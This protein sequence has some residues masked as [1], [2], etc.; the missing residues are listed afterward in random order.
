[1]S[2][3]AAIAQ[4]QAHQKI[5]KMKTNAGFL[6]FKL[7]QPTS[8]ETETVEHKSMLL[9]IDA[10]SDLEMLLA[11]IASMPYK[12]ATNFSICLCLLQHKNLS[13]QC[14]QVHVPGLWHKLSAEIHVNAYFISSLLEPPYRKKI[15]CLVTCQQIF[16]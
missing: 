3:S 6:S 16:L 14:M 13:T 1:M 9:I 5:T 12:S 15:N 7:Q 11:C 8:Y 10:P 4:F 2:R